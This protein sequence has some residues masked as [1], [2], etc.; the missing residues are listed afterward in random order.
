M[1]VPANSTDPARAGS[2]PASVISSVVFPAP[3]APTIAQSV[4]SSS[5]IATSWRMSMLP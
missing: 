2:R 3:F 1:S 5:A 4:P